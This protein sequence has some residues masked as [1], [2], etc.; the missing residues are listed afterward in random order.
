MTD[1]IL[2]SNEHQSVLDG[3]E[4]TAVP[5]PSSLSSSH[6]LHP[7]LNPNPE[8]IFSDEKVSSVFVKHSP[9][10]AG[11]DLCAFIKNPISIKPNESILISTGVRLWLKNPAL[12]AKCYPRSGLGSR[13]LVLKNLVGVIDSDY[14]GEIK[15]CLWNTSSSA[16]TVNPYDRVAQLV[17]EY[18]PLVQLTSVDEFSNLTKRGTGGFGST[19][20]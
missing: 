10:A 16:I 15:L 17:I 9:G 11:Y 4:P 19:G 5:A 8:V 14:Q 1:S 7:D 6:H 12:V 13:G 2:N 20:N 18:V 3:F